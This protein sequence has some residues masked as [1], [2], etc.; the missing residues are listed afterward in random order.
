MILPTVE[1]L[2]EILVKEIYDHAPHWTGDDIM[3]FTCGAHSA[4]DYIKKI[5]KT[6]EHEQPTN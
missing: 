1:Q 6:E 5:N 4:L 3:L 2:D